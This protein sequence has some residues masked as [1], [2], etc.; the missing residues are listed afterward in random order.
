MLRVICEQCQEVGFTASPDYTR[1]EC[2]GGLKIFPWPEEEYDS[3]KAK[4]NVHARNMEARRKLIP[5]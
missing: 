4:N 5:D 1:C 3:Q 2:G